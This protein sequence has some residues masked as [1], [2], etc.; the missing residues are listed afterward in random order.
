MC[1]NEENRGCSRQTELQALRSKNATFC[2]CAVKPIKSKQYCEL[3]AGLNPVYRKIIFDPDSG[4]PS[5]VPLDPRVIDLVA[6]HVFISSMSPSPSKARWQKQIQNNKHAHYGGTVPGMGLGKKLFIQHE[7]ARR[8]LSHDLIFRPKKPLRKKSMSEVITSDDAFLSHKAS[9]FG[10]TW[11]RVGQPISHKMLRK[12]RGTVP[13]LSCLSDHVLGCLVVSFAPEKSVVFLP[14]PSICFPELSQSL[15]FRVFVWF[16]TC[17]SISG[18]KKRAQW[19]TSFGVRRPPGGVG[20]FH[21]NGCRNFVGVS[22]SPWG[23]SKSLCKKKFVLIFRPLHVF[24]LLIDSVQCHLSTS[25]NCAPSLLKPFSFDRR[26][27]LL[28]LSRCFVW[29]F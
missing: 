7:S 24:P 26:A 21:A 11:Y 17:L 6:D 13:R 5:P 4:F 8:R 14:G 20:V 28:P 19:L 15:R 2:V 29:A 1:Q 12:I 18:K 23:C 22:R 16:L 25:P 3:V 10:T 9:M 27:L